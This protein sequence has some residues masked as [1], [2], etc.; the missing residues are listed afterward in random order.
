MDAIDID[1]YRVIGC[2]IYRLGIFYV[3]EVVERGKS[4]EWDDVALGILYKKMIKDSLTVDVSV[5]IQ[6]FIVESLK[7]WSCMDW[8]YIK[9]SGHE[10]MSI[11]CE[12]VKKE[13]KEL[14]KENIV[15]NAEIYNSI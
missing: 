11:L 14:I 10:Y 4:V 12:E 6:K 5:D 9:F 13:V 8:M 3:F 15:E 2:E 1:E 7:S